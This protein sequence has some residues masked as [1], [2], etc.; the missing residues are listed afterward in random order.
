VRAQDEEARYDIEESLAALNH[1]LEAIR[2]DGASPI[3][4]A[5]LEQMIAELEAQR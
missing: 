5:V 3:P 4:M 2:H 1:R